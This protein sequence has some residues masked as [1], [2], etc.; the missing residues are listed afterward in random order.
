MQTK[1]KDVEYRIKEAGKR[2]F[3]EKG[4]QG[5]SVCRIAEAAGVPIGN[6]YRYFPSKKALLDGVVGEAYD[7]IPKFITD[8]AGTATVLEM[9]L[10]QFSSFIAKELYRVFWRRRAELSILLYKC[11][12]TEYERFH[13]VIDERIF[14]II[15]T[16]NF[17]DGKITESE[18]ILAKV[19]ANGYL[20]GVLEML[21]MEWDEAKFTELVQKITL[22]FFRE[23]KARG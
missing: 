21:N 7:F 23:F 20:D 14:N 12:G 9:P 4:Y 19:V 16:R 15:V 1:K 13:D 5:G 11:Q 17:G 22:F 6:L 18:R 2:E 3:L 8:L 10:E